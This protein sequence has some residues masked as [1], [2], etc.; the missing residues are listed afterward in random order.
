MR[1]NLSLV[2]TDEPHRFVACIDMEL[3]TAQESKANLS[4]ADTGFA[5]Q[6]EL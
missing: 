6:R 4:L 5:K 1:C 2:Q 3:E